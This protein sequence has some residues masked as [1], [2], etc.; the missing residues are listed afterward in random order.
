MGKATVITTGRRCVG[1]LSVQQNK[2]PAAESG[3]AVNKVIFLDVDGVFNNGTWAIE[4]FDKGSV[5]NTICFCI[6]LAMQRLG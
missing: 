6:I 5:D 1:L 4:M 3:Q 2:N